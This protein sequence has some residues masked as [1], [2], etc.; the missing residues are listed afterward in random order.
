MFRVPTILL[1][2]D[3]KFDSFVPSFLDSRLQLVD[4]V[5][6]WSPVVPVYH[7]PVLGVFGVPPRHAQARHH[8]YH[9]QHGGDLPDPGIK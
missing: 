9:R 5:V 1:L 8:H 4:V 6:A 3:I 7:L 2:Q